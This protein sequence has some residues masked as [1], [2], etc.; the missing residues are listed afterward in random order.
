MSR[1]KVSVYRT[2]L[3]ED[4]VEARV[5]QDLHWYNTTPYAH[6]T[7]AVFVPAGPA[8]EALIGRLVAAFRA[9]KADQKGDPQLRFYLEPGFGRGIL[10]RLEELDVR[11]PRLQ[12][13]PAIRSGE[14][15]VVLG[16]LQALSRAFGK[17][18]LDCRVAFMPARAEDLPGVA[19]ALERALAEPALARLLAAF[20][21]VELGFEAA[22]PGE[23]IEAAVADLWA[24]HPRLVESVNAGVSGYVRRFYALKEAWHLARITGRPMR[25][26][27]GE[28]AVGEAAAARIRAFDRAF[29]DTHASLDWYARSRHR[30][31]SAIL[32]FDLDSI[33][34]TYE[35]QSP[36]FIDGR[37]ILDRDRLAGQ[38]DPVATRSAVLSQAQA[39]GAA[40]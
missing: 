28:D 23:T 21:V 4:A 38:N 11:L 18:L 39:E 6:L 40:S 10:D 12:V 26:P 2:D 32:E 20:P 27:G 25:E 19:A 31:A 34:D 37:W 9:G 30:A 14:P 8:G 36:V 7:V 13:C 3:P 15:A 35:C 16:S 22:D 1:K 17:R 5:A 29:L 24:A 33:A